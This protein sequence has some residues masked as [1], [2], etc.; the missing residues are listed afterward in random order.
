MRDHQAALFANGFVFLEGPRW[1][2]GCLWVSDM[3]DNTVYRIAPDGARTVVVRTAQ[4]PSGLGFLPDGTP[5]VVSMG[6]R[7]VL[8]IVDGA[9]EPYA[10]LSAIATGDANDMIVDSRGRAY[11]GNL[12]Y[13]VFAGEEPAPADIALVDVDGSV[14]TAAART[15]FPNGMVL[16]DD[17]RVLVLAETWAKRLIAY[18]READGLLSGRRLYADLGERTPDGICLDQDGGI[19]ISSF[20]TSE[21]V[22]VVEGGA[23]TDRVAC[24]GRMAVACALGGEDGHTL[25]CVTFS[26]ELEDMQNRRRK[27]AIE[28]VRVDVGAAGPRSAD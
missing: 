25:F 23:V 26:G 1:R 8:K 10:D 9:A 13:D 6:D 17:E 20:H 15:E 7:K 27:A 21:F 14:R 22:R 4:R 28:T 11:V 5:L 16:I 2:N 3:A 24:P 12:G 18:D 19:W